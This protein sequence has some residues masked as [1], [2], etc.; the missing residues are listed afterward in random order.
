MRA[1][2]LKLSPAEMITELLQIKGIS[3]LLA[4]RRCRIYARWWIFITMIRTMNERSRSLLSKQRS[5]LRKMWLSKMWHNPL[6]QIWIE[7]RQMSIYK[8]LL[9]NGTAMHVQLCKE[10]CQTQIIWKRLLIFLATKDVPIP[11]LAILVLLLVLHQAHQST[12]NTITA[13]SLCRPH[14][15]APA[16]AVLTKMSQ[17]KK[18]RMWIGSLS[19]TKN[20]VI[21]KNGL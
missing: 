19:L 1:I 17:R 5:L 6:L 20:L 9:N 10:W 2:H 7:T 15:S 16:P 13:I 11:Q 8:N 14:T 18:K 21:L 12:V 4:W 3:I